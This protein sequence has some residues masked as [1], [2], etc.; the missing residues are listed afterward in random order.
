[1]TTLLNKIHEQKSNFFDY[2]IYVVIII[3]SILLGLETDNELRINHSFILSC[4]DDIILAIF[5]LEIIIKVIA[6]GKKPWKYFSNPWNIF[7]F[8][9]VLISFLPFILTNG[10]EDTRAF[11][12]L[13]L[14]RLARL[15]RAFRVFRLVTHL[16]PLQ[17]LIET[18]IKSIPSMGYIVFLLGI[19]FYIYGIIG[20][21]LFGTTDVTNFGN[22]GNS[23]L[24]LFVC[25]T[26]GWTELMK[27]LMVT[28]GNLGM[29]E[30]LFVPFYFISFYF[31]AGMIVLNLF[32]GVLIQN[33][34]EANAERERETIRESFSDNLD[35]ESI[36]LVN[37]LETQ[38][39]SI[40]DTFKK[41]QL[42]LDKELGK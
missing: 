10:Q 6:E 37:Q 21:F 20:V 9:I 3:S 11:A 22:L 5:T 4:A 12:A 26:G 31:L 7:D 15:T 29:I 24:S 38:I 16:K 19:L 42:S 39:S 1:M 30:Y 27:G 17:I 34:T 40:N 13:R 33:L 35:A 18:L 23:M 25:A 8:T 14:I 32:V 41:L 36:K 28:N 2:F